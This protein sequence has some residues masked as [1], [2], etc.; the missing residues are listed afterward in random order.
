MRANKKDILTDVL[1]NSKDSKIK[2]KLSQLC[3][4]LNMKYIHITSVEL[5]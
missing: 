2:T 4:I 5:H 1:Y 3:Q